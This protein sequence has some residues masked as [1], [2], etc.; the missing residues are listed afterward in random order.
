[1]PSNIR[2]F[3][4]DLKKFGEEVVPDAVSDV[5]KKLALEILERVVIKTPVDT[6]RARSNWLVAIDSIPSGEISSEQL[7]PEQATSIALNN[8]VPV[9]EN[10]KPFT[11]IAIANNVPYIG[12]LEFGRD[13]GK[14]GSKQAPNG[15][16]RVT[17]A[18]IE[19]MFT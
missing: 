12:V 4:L 14:P 3:S 1:M 9:I 11:S 8:G 6:G 18:E 17:L 19:T 10:A 7:T 13:D 2:K 15:M 5:A 16:V